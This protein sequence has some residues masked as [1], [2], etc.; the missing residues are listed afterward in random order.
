MKRL[1]FTVFALVLILSISTPVLAAEKVTIIYQN[2]LHGWLFP[3]S[4][5]VGMVEMTR[6]LS[7]LFRENP[8]SFYAM[9]GDLF[10]GPNLPD[11]MKGLA[12]LEIWNHFQREMEGQGFGDRVLISAGNHEFDYGVPAP[13]SFWS[14]LLCANLL[15]AK[16]RPFYIPSRVI[17]CRSGLKVGFV[18]LLLT[19]DRRVLAATG[20]EGLKMIP[21][22]EALK[23]AIPAMGDLDLTVLM[24]H[25]TMGKILRLARALPPNLGV[26]LILSGHDHIVQEE[27]IRENGIYI[28]QAGAMNLYYGRVDLSVEDRKVV[29]VK[30]RIVTQIPSPL[31]HVTLL[32]KEEVDALAGKSVALLKRPLSGVGQRREENSLGDFVTDAFRWATGTDVAMTNS[33]S[34]RMDLRV[35]QDRYRRLNR[36]D[37]K[38]VCPFRDHLV[39]GRLTGAQIIEILE[40]DAVNFTNQVSGITYRVD[41]GKPPGKRVVE[42]KIGG[43]PVSLE[44]VYTLTHNDYCTRPENMGKYLHLAPRSVAWKKTEL[45]D[46]EVVTDYARHLKVIDYPTAGEKR[47]VFIR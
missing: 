44:R 18:G 13:H 36:G 1:R 21:M 11:K 20:A 8:N 9:S 41:L 3:S 31:E 29:A 42:A 17:Q 34:L 23:K 19:G 37:F 32:I 26:D 43:A 25:D 46:Y 39:V 6:I 27:P 30:N 7:P 24:I 5:G 47:V 15:T 22:L 45:I 28:F 35:Y 40:G 12:E 2:D 38:A 16:N 4:T 33:S 14:G 10:T